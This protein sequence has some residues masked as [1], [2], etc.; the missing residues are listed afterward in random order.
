MSSAKKEIVHI[1]PISYPNSFFWLA[2]G[3]KMHVEFEMDLFRFQFFAREAGISQIIN[4]M[5][6]LILQISR[7][8]AH[9]I[10]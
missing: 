6:F 9:S 7:R 2:T 8:A 5:Q 10:K 3:I 4:T 1:C